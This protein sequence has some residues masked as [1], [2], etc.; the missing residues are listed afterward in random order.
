MAKILEIEAKTTNYRS[1]CIDDRWF[2]L[3]ILSHIFFLYRC[4]VTIN[5]TH[6]YD[7]NIIKP[8]S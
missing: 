8:P 4:I 7:A 3:F 1:L 6:K 2:F 5:F